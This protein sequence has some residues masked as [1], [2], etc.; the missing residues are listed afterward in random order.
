M[1]VFT[2]FSIVCG[3]ILLA[4]S[5]VGIMRVAYGQQNRL[6][7]GY[8]LYGSEVDGYSGVS[9]RI[10]T[11]NPTISGQNFIAEWGS[12]VLKYFPY[13]YWL[14]IGYTKGWDTN[15]QLKYFWEIQDV[16]YYRKGFFGAPNPS[17]V[18][19]YLIAH[20]YDYGES[21]YEE[22]WRFYVDG[23]TVMVDLVEP[24]VA[25]D[26]QAKVETTSSS[27]VIDG[28]HFQR[29]SYLTND[30]YWHWVFWETHLPYCDHPPYSLTQT[31]DY[32]FYANGGG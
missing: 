29:L 14:Q 2:R 27:M 26:Q 21:I 31:E 22:E 18:H 24:H 3:A 6:Y 16:Y 15:F 30:H 23:A 10:F 7:A 20:P 4:V 17:T 25:R 8:W 12:I 19:A 32:E 13:R 28:S 11:I 9:E 1:Q 5:S